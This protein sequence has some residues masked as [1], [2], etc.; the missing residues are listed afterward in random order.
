VGDY[1]VLKLT[2]PGRRALAGE[3]RPLLLA[4][5]AAR[6]APKA[7]VEKDSWDGV[8]RALFERLRALRRTLAAEAGVPAYIVFGDATLRDLARK[9]PA[10]PEEL[11]EV[12]G[13]G[14]KKLELYGAR[15]LAEVRAHDPLQ[16]GPGVG[17]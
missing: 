5:P 14:A 3:E 12:T 9:K 15:V 4:A 10:T 1:G 2:A 8:D 16:T 6:R 13:I 7:A 11:L 17:R